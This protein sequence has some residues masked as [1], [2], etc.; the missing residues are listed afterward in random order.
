[1]MVDHAMSRAQLV[2]LAATMV[3]T[4][5]LAVAVLRWQQGG[6][7]PV[8]VRA[9]GPAADSERPSRYS[10]L[11]GNRP[12][13]ASVPRPAEPAPVSEP[14]TVA[15]PVAVAPVAAAPATV[16]LGPEIE[17][18][19]RTAP[20]RDNQGTLLGIRVFPGHETAQFYQSGLKGGDL[21][22]AINGTPIDDSEASKAQW[23]RL[24]TGSTVTVQRRGKREDVTLN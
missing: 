2:T 15:Q 21:V 13:L 4:F 14:R 12:P 5:V 3:I 22:V 6:S 24:A 10:P 20:L 11:G 19:A 23:A 8:P 17:Q 7:M 16:T 18:I 1:M 9:Q